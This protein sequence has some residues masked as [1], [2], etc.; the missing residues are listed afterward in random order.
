MLNSLK[1]CNKA[2]PSCSFITLAKSKLQ[3]VRLSVTEILRVF[4]KTLTD[5]EPI[6]FIIGRIYRNQFN[7]NYLRNKK[8]S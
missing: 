4:V 5:D 2:L 6:I 7:F 8:T 1:K 3:N